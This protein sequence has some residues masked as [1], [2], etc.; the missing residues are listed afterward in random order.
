V[1][2]FA[3]TGSLDRLEY[4]ILD[5]AIVHQLVLGNM[6]DNNPEM[7]LRE[8]LLKLKAPI[9]G[10]QDVELFLRYSQEG[11]VF[12]RVPALLVNRCDLVIAEEQL[13]ARVYAFVKKDTHSRSW[14][15]AKSRT[16]N[17]CRRVIGGYRLMNSSIVSPPSRKSIRL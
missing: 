4:F 15:L 13:G 11:S 7:Q 14:L 10:Q 5:H 3:G 1:Y 16:A 9:N 6:G 8:I 2:H 12:Q 17:T